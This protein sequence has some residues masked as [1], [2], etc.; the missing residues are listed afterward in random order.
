VVEA[1]GFVD[2]S[3][4]DDAFGEATCLLLP[5]TRE[6]YG[7]VVIEAASVGTPSVVVAGP[8]NA[9]VE[10]IVEGVN[11]HV[12][13]SGSAPDL[14][15]AIAAV[16]EE[17]DRLR[18]RTAAWFAEAAPTLTAEASARTVLAVYARR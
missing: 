5:S 8:D 1:P 7:L 16:H 15:A 6:G 4:I 12:A 14:A 2:G 11:G 18:E 13:P 10:L 3:V 9:A 17:G